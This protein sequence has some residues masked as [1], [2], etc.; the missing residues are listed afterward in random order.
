MLRGVGKV[1]STS[2]VS[3]VCLVTDWTSTSGDD[4]DTVIVSSSDPTFMS[5]FTLAVKSVDSSIPSRFTVEKPGSVKVT[6]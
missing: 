2:R 1:S 5:A 6:V 4:P 3:T